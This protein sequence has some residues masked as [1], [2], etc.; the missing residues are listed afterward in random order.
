MLHTAVPTRVRLALRLVDTRRVERAD[1]LEV[2]KIGI[3]GSD[4]AAVGLNPYE[5]KLELWLAREFLAS[6]TLPC[7]MSTFP[8]NCSDIM[9]ARSSTGQAHYGKS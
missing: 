6:E 8:C 2:R 3:C 5:S 9:L 1:W 4:A 7:C